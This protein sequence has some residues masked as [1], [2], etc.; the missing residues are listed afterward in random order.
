M[1]EVPEELRL[2]LEADDR[3]RLERVIAA[4]DEEDFETLQ[5]LVAD[6]ETTS[7]FRRRALFAL[8]R[9]PGRGQAAI[10]TIRSSLPRLDEVERMGAINAL[11][12]IGTEQA[13]D[14]VVAYVHDPAADVRRQVAKALDRIGTP[15]AAAA[16]RDLAASERVDYVRDRAEELLRGKRGTPSNPIED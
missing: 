4:G 13:L 2:A 1:I 14:V 3:D 8:G 12:R 7:S 15:R 6:G 9:W 11:G 10:A 16:L 5:A